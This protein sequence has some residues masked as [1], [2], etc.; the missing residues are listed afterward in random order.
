MEYK[1]SS[2]NG[3]PVDEEFSSETFE[4][5]PDQETEMGVY[6]F[7]ESGE[8][9]S[10]M[11]PEELENFNKSFNSFLKNSYNEINAAKEEVSKGL[12]DQSTQSQDEIGQNGT[13]SSSGTLESRVIQPPYPPKCLT[14]LIDGDSTASKSI[15]KKVRD[16][17]SRKISFKPIG[18]I[19]PQDADLDAANTDFYEHSEFITQEQFDTDCRK[20]QDFMNSQSDCDEDFQETCFKVFSDREAVGWGAFEVIRA[21]SGI[22]AQIN[23]LPA[24]NIRRLRGFEGFVEINGLD[25]MGRNQYTY[26]QNFGEKVVVE[27]LDPF[28]PDTFNP[29]VV[30]KPNRKVPYD[31]EKHGELFIGQNGIDFNLKDR[32]GNPTENFQEA[33]NEVLFVPKSHRGSRYYGI[34]SNLSVIAPMLANSFIDSHIIQYFEHNCVPRYAVS[35]TGANADKKLIDRIS[36]FLSTEVKGNQHK[37]LVFAPKSGLG[38]KVEVK[39]IKLDADNK[40]QDFINSYKANAQRIM[41]ANGLSPAL[42]GIAENASIGSGRGSSQAENY[43]NLESLPSQLY[44]ARRVNKLFR[45][46]LGCKYARLEYDPLNIKDSEAL[47]RIIQILLVQGV[48]SIN[49]ARNELGKGPI[50]GGDEPFVRMKGASMVKVSDMPDMQSMVA[51]MVQNAP[52][53]LADEDDSDTFGPESSD[54]PPT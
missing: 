18:T 45:L 4:I 30:D 28:N 47:A 29:D 11:S 22:I 15:E 13:I 26:Y 48:I 39:F 10:E 43:K 23:H 49:E 1:L 32:Q 40:E 52:N 31:P 54:L 3:V 53:L 38:S 6:V 8:E 25:S 44:A 51:D 34:S 21:A 2:I 36:K 50:R 7:D 27:E 5:N 20:I 24:C 35:I 12:F 16:S 14:D 17:T 33:C 41:T 37:T 19:K 46:G 9:V 42:L